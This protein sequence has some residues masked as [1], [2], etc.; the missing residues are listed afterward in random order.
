MKQESIMVKLSRQEVMRLEMIVIDSDKDEALSFL[1][2]LRQKVQ[3]T[4][5]G[6]KCHLD[7]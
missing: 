6:M 7:I 1:K 5:K 3:T 2:E 4:T